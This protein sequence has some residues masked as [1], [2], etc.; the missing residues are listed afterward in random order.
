MYIDLLQQ[1]AA[2]TSTSARNRKKRKQEEEEAGTIA[3]DCNKSL[4]LSTRR[5]NTTKTKAMKDM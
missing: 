1:F 2:N 3:Q 4:V 5:F